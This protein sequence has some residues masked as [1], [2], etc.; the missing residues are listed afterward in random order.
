MLIEKRGQLTQNIAA[1]L[2]E[3][4]SAEGGHH[5]ADL[6]DMDDVADKD[7]VFEIVN[8]ESDT[9]ERITKALQRID[10]GTYGKC[11]DCGGEIGIERL[12]ALPFATQCIACKK[13]EESQAFGD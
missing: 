5:L 9:V 1:G 6:E 3:I 11:E 4:E 13:K 12:E 8:A 2:S 7:A 10:S